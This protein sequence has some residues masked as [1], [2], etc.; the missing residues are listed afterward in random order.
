MVEKYPLLEEPGKTMFVFA[1]NGKY[2]GHIIKDRTDKG[3]AKFLFETPR[4]ESVEALKSDYPPATASG[5]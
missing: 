2:Y 4:Y 3:P 1:A 5:G